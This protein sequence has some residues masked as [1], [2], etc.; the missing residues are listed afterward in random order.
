MTENIDK[1]SIARKVANEVIERDIK[2]QP[3]SAENLESLLMEITG[4]EEITYLAI[5][6]IEDDPRVRVE[7]KGREEDWAIWVYHKA[8]IANV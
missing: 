3:R 7:S 5:K 2:R 6:I 1:P 8:P 4:D